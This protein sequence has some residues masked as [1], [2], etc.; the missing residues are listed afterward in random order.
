[1]SR[2]VIEVRIQQ[3]DTGF[4]AMF[5]LLCGVLVIWHF[6]EWILLGLGVLAAAFVIWV[7]WHKIRGDFRREAARQAELIARADRQL[8]GWMAE[9]PRATYGW[10]D[11][12]ERQEPQ[13]S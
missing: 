3:A 4:W 12:D 5:W 1:M 6:I 7:L 2:E 13:P 11:D 10:G 9:D 8:D